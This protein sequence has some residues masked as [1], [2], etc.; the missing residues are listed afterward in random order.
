LKEATREIGKKEGEKGKLKIHTSRRRVTIGW[1]KEEDV[2][3]GSRR[4]FPGRGAFNRKCRPGAE[5]GANS[6]NNAF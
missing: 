3:G 2:R 1:G 5:R 4:N 6:G